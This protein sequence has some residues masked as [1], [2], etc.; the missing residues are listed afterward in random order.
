MTVHPSSQRMSLKFLPRLGLL[1][2]KH[3]LMIFTWKRAS[4]WTPAVGDRSE[5]SDWLVGD[6]L[7][8]DRVVVSPDITHSLDTHTDTQTATALR[9]P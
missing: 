8:Q 6:M 5:E 9:H 4:L 3:T 7:L 2:R 1:L